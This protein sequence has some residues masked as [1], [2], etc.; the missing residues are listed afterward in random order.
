MSLFLTKY[1]FPVTLAALIWL[2]W[3]MFSNN[4]SDL[5]ML[6]L[7]SWQLEGGAYI[8][9]VTLFWNLCSIT[10]KGG[11]KRHKCSA[12]DHYYLSDL[13]LLR[14]NLLDHE[15]RNWQHRESGRSELVLWMWQFLNCQE[16]RSFRSHVFSLN[17][18]TTLKITVFVLSMKPFS[19]GF[20]YPGSCDV[21]HSTSSICQ[22][23]PSL[24]HNTVHSIQSF[25]LCPAFSMQQVISVWVRDPRMQKN[26]FWH[27]YIDYE[28]CLHVSKMLKTVGRIVILSFRAF[29]LWYVCDTGVSCFRP[30]VCASPR[31]SHKWEGDTVSLYGSGENCRQIRC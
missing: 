13:Q 7:L 10:C 22:Y 2:C 29:L 19:V 23:N 28:I 30:T 31:R 6:V 24:F 14:L 16:E 25:S 20:S 9:L 11:N 12:K 15:K 21:S 8:S 18:G 27:A 5:G 17:C 4:A 26:D 1:G 3:H